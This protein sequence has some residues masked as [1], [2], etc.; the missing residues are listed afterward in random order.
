[1]YLLLTAELE[2][3]WSLGEEEEP[4]GWCKNRESWSCRVKLRKGEVWGR[5]RDVHLMAEKRSEESERRAGAAAVKKLFAPQLL[6]SL[7]QKQ[8][9]RCEVT[10]AVRASWHLLR[11]DPVMFSRRLLNIVMEDSLIH[12]RALLVTWAL[13]AVSKGWSVDMGVAAE[14]LNVVAEIAACG[15]H[16]VCVFDDSF[17]PEPLHDELSPL[18]TSSALPW[19]PSSCLAILLR[20]CYG[21]MKGDMTFLRCAVGVW[22][23][24]LEENGEEWSKFV[25]D[26]WKEVQVKKGI[27]IDASCLSDAQFLQSLELREEDHVGYAVDFHCFGARYVQEIQRY[28]R[29]RSP[30][31]SSVPESDIKSAVWFW[32]SGVYRKE[33]LSSAEFPLSLSLQ[34][35]RASQVEGME[36]TGRV[37]RMISKAVD[38]VAPRFW[39]QT[40]KGRKR[41]KSESGGSAA[42]QKKRKAADNSKEIAC[43]TAKITNFFQRRQC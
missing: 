21:G 24:R 13:M 8:V 10:S 16:D 2:V 25:I 18:V 41:T 35:M 40:W 6:Q 32:R 11:Q 15:F 36:R 39:L 7:V 3:K 12:P 4:A 23:K 38:E 34:R 26:A 14:L 37:W 1:M 19:A 28:L 22:R 42:P 29:E 31:I 33:A 9:R 27:H 30:G 43:G 5:S 17:L 20:V